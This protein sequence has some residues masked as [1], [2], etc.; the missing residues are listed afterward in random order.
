[1]GAIKKYE[2]QVLTLPHSD[3]NPIAEIIDRYKANSGVGF[4]GCKPHPTYDSKH[5]KN[6]MVDQ[7]QWT[8]RMD[9]EKAREIEYALN[10]ESTVYRF[11]LIENINYK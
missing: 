5:D 2:L 10:N 7:H 9:C 1:M 4:T 6:I 3:L 8:F 11:M